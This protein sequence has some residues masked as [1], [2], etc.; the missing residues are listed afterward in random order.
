MYYINRALCILLLWL[1]LTSF[2]HFN[3]STW[4]LIFIVYLTEL[5]SIQDMNETQHR[6][7]CE[8]VPGKIQ[9]KHLVTSGKEP[10]TYQSNDCTK[11]K[12]VK[13]WVNDCHLQEYRWR[14]TY[15]SRNNSKTVP[16]LKSPP[17]LGNDKNVGGV[18]VYLVL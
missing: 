8:T 6:M 14:V 13:Q 3:P 18:L 12:W 9:P 4:W 15:R 10:P 1:K 17:S 7:L 5:R 2:Q 11:D 16:S